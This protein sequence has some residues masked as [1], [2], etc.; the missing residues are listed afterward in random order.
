MQKIDHFFKQKKSGFIAWNSTK[1]G[2]DWTRISGFGDQRA[3]IAPPSY[4][5]I[6]SITKN[7]HIFLAITAHRK[8]KSL[9]SLCIVFANSDNVEPVVVTSSI[10]KTVLQFGNFDKSSI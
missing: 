10:S 6:A 8:S 5:F 1:K 9:L 7:Y 2:G 4:F 3:T